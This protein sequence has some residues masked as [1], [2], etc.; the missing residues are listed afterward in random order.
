MKKPS[1]GEPLSFFFSEKG[2]DP[3]ND[4]LKIPKMR[5]RGTPCQIFLMSLQSCTEFIFF[6]KQNFHIHGIGSNQ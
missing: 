4:S 6:E 3:A 1:I 5:Y 2:T